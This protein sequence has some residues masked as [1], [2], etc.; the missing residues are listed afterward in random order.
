MS[1]RERSAHFN[2]RP[3]NPCLRVGS[4]W[5]CRLSEVGALRALRSTTRAGFVFLFPGRIA[6]WARARRWQWS[7][8]SDLTRPQ[9]L[10]CS[11]WRPFFSSLQQAEVFVL[12]AA[13]ASAAVT[14]G[15][16]VVSLVSSLG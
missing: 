5:R 2:R 16:L 8:D 13:V 15:L 3:G 12:G 10:S 1:F 9:P 6:T 7:G 4:R 14:F 11:R